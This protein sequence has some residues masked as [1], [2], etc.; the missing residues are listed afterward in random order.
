VPDALKTSA[1]VKYGRHHIWGAVDPFNVC[2][3]IGGC[4]ILC[5]LTIR[6]LGFDI[7]CWE[8]S[9]FLRQEYRGH[10]PVPLGDDPDLGAVRHEV[11]RQKAVAI[12][13]GAIVGGP[14][15]RA[16]GS[17]IPSL[18]ALEPVLEKVWWH[19]LEGGGGGDN[20]AEWEWRIHRLFY[21]LAMNQ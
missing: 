2:H 4:L 8:E 18:V 7:A 11:G 17:P 16:D 20:L 19:Q 5:A 14:V 6:V 13:K 3:W 21:R 15:L 10:R 1:P 9:I 12:G